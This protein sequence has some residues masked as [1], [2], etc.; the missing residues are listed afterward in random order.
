[1]LRGRFKYWTR[2]LR[3]AVNVESYK[4]FECRLAHKANMACY[5]SGVALANDLLAFEIEPQQSDTTPINKRALSIISEFDSRIQHTQKLKTLLSKMIVFLRQTFHFD[6]AMV[7]QF[8]TDCTGT[9]V[10][11][12]SVQAMS[13]Y[14]GLKFPST[15]VPKPARQML[16]QVPFRYT[17]DVHYQG[18]DVTTSADIKQYLQL[19]TCRVSPVAPVHKNYLNNMGVRA[20]LTIPLIIDNKLWGLIAFHHRQVKHI[21]PINRQLLRILANNLQLA[22]QHKNILQDQKNADQAITLQNHLKEIAA[23]AGTDIWQALKRLQASLFQV[24]RCQGFAL[25]ANDKIYTYGQTPSKHNIKIF[26]QWVNQ[27]H[28]ENFYTNHLPKLD[29]RF[30]NWRQYGCGV[31]SVR[32]LL[33]DEYYFIIFRKELQKEVTWAGNPNEAYHINEQ[34]G[35]Y[36]PRA[37]FE[38]WRDKQKFEAKHWSDFDHKTISAL[39][40]VILEYLTQ[41]LLYDSANTDYLTKAYNRNYL[42]RQLQAMMENRDYKNDLSVI[43]FDIDYFKKVNDTFGHQA[44]DYILKQLVSFLHAQLRRTDFVARYGGEEFLVILDNCGCANAAKIA[45]KLRVDF[46]QKTWVY[47]GQNLGQI[48][49]SAGVAASSYACNDIQYLISHADNALYKAKQAGR[50]QIMVYDRL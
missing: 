15:D 50:N 29:K 26:L 36:T 43:I 34:T 42:F 46:T 2:Q 49:F 28:S 48:T 12:S 22:I 14:L 8:D 25:V 30:E 21:S 31:Y 27:Y 37:S 5:I 3:H 33:K 19:T 1:M 41:E 11:E 45:E 24:L 23:C 39:Q 4:V 18:L 16:R 38:R 32:L 6:K 7:Y 9:V 20:S 44:G 40:Y 35:H 10:A 13:S 17:P 47:E